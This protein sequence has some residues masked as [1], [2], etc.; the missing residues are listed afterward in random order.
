MKKLIRNLILELLEDGT[1]SEE[2]I[3]IL[4]RIL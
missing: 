3:D 1:S 4:L 2:I